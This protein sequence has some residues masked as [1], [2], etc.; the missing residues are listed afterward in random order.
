MGKPWENGGLMEFNGIWNGMYPLGMTVAFENGP[1][2][3]V[4]LPMEHDD[5]PFIVD[6][7]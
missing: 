2:E 7:H 6:F 1:V 3:I 5:F 4:D